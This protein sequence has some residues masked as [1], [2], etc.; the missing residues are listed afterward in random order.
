MVSDVDLCNLALARLGSSPIVTI[1]EATTNGELCERFYPVIYDRVLRSHNWKCAIERAVLAQTTAPVFEYD[2]AYQL[3]ADPFCLRVIH[4]NNRDDQFTIEG[5][6]LLTNDSPANIKYVSRTLTGNLDPELVRI[7]Y[8]NIAI[9]LA[10]AVTGKSDI[11]A[12]LERELEGRAFPEATI[13][14]IIEELEPGQTGLEYT[15]L[16]A[17]M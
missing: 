16:T 17:R 15:W 14:N 12:D 13:A 10:L 6:K 3:P 11:K 1:G 9:E 4:L 8:L 5:R 2:F 7:I